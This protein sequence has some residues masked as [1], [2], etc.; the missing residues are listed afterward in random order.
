MSKI[1]FI[2][3]I[4][5]THQIILQNLKKSFGFQKIPSINR[6]IKNVYRLG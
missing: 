1:L 2:V 5:P 4:L 6:L 3:I